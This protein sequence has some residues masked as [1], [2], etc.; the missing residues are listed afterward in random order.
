MGLFLVSFLFI[1][2]DSPCIDT[3]LMSCRVLKRG[4]ELAAFHTIC[5]YAQN[6]AVKRLWGNIFLQKES[7]RL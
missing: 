7:H 5:D 2:N 3:E 4:V 6:G 1:D